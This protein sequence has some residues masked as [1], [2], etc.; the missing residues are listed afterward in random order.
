MTVP[1]L[2]IQSLIKLTD[3]LTVDHYREF[4]YTILTRELGSL[5]LIRFGKQ[6]TCA[7][8]R[9]ENDVEALHK[10]ISRPDLIDKL[11]VNNCKAVKR[12]RELYPDIDESL[13]GWDLFVAFDIEMRNIGRRYLQYARPDTAKRLVEHMMNVPYEYKLSIS[14]LSG[15]T[16]VD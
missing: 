10:L 11:T 7:I 16:I 4:T 6:R 8:I 9:A 3:M 5:F 2:T 1:S 13:D 15:S 12:F 14:E